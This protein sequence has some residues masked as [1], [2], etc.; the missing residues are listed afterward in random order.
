MYVPH[1][2]CES[3]QQAVLWKL[4]WSNVSAAAAA[5]GGGV[6][7][8]ACCVSGSMLFLALL[9]SL[10]HPAVSGSGYR[11]LHPSQLHLHHTLV[12][13]RHPHPQLNIPQHPPAFY[14]NPPLKPL[15]SRKDTHQQPLC[16]QGRRAPTLQGNGCYC[17]QSGTIGVKMQEC[18][19]INKWRQRPA[20]QQHTQLGLSLSSFRCIFRFLLTTTCCYDNG[21]RG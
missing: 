16:C 19:A 5:A 2:V 15:R 10:S 14:H 13:T 20:V 4:Q 1:G 9:P 6:L 11:T 3:S 21:E 7:C 12:S 8:S 18:Q 17:C